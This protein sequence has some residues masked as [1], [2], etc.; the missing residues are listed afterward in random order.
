VGG[1][2]PE[3]S[4]PDQIPQPMGRG[5]ARSADSAEAKDREGRERAIHAPLFLRSQLTT[6]VD[7]TQACT[8]RARSHR[9]TPEAGWAHRRT[10]G[11]GGGRVTGRRLRRAHPGL[12]AVWR[13][14]G[15]G[16][17]QAA[18]GGTMWPSGGR[19]STRTRSRESRIRVKAQRSRASQP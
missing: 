14:A 17:S 6:W 15:R 4:I 19:R 1:C 10:G 3:L 9:K 16:R 5:P 7:C 2:R 13:R 11:R 12:G 18:G 8:S